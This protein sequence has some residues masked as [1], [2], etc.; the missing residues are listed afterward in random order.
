MALEDKKHVLAEQTLESGVAEG[1]C[2]LYV[3]DYN[4]FKVLSLYSDLNRHLIAYK[5]LHQGDYYQEPWLN[6]SF[7]SVQQVDFNLDI[8]LL[9]AHFAQGNVK[10]TVPFVVEGRQASINSNHFIYGISRYNELR[11]ELIKVYLFKHEQYFNIIIFKEKACVFC[12]T[13][14][15]QNDTEMLYFTLSALQ[16]VE[17]KQDD[18]AVFIDY[19]LSTLPQT[20]AFLKPYFKSVQV[21]QMD[22]DLSEDDFEQ[23]PQLLFINYAMS[24]CE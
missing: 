2:N 20:A 5:V 1:L 9:P 13:F 4:Q 17:C 10:E 11:P 16:T 12:N 8:Q 18:A 3:C 15:C 22:M 21:L 14:N 7:R 23:L 6:Q 19:P 24:L